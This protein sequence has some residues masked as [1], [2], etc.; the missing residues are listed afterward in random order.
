MSWASWGPQAPWGPAKGSFW[1]VAGQTTSPFWASVSPWEKGD[2]LLGPA[3]LSLI[4][5][6]CILPKKRPSTGGGPLIPQWALASPR[7]QGLSPPKLAS[8][9]SFLPSAMQGAH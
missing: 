4:D 1:T 5:A 8:P 9:C 3:S 2:S 7:M 6:G